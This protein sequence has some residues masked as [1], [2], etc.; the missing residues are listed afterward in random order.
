MQDS[1]SKRDDYRIYIL[2]CADGSLYTGIAC[3]VQ[4]RINEHEQGTRGAK[5]LRGRLP[6]TLVF[7][8]VVGTRSSA[9]RIEHRVKKLSRAKKLDLV[10]GKLTLDSLREDQI[11]GSCFSS[12]KSSNG[13]ANTGR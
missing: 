2:R 8:R 5:Y 7:E 13:T 6:A 9:L 12:G 11:S 10:A 3:D 4:S 1:V